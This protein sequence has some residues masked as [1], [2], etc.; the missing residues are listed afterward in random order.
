MGENDLLIHLDSKMDRI[1]EG[2][3]KDRERLVRVEDLTSG[4]RAE[5]LAVK[6]AQETCPG[7]IAEMSRQARRAA[8]LTAGK[9]LGWVIGVVT[10]LAG[11]WQAVA[12][13]FG[14]P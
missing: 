1:L 7:R 4:L 11:A 10:A 5:I 9:L 13:I 14:G 6:Q 2:Q 12:A 3:S 8:W